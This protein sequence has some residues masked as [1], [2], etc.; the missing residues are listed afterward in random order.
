MLHHVDVANEGGDILSLPLGQP[1]SG[2]ILTGID[3]LDPG[4]AT[5]IS[6][7]YA[8]QDGSEFHFARRES[9]NILMGFA[10]DSRF[11]GGTTRL[12]REQLYKYFMPKAKIFL[13]MS[14][15]NDLEVQIDGVVESLQSPMF[16]EKPVAVASIIC[17]DPDFYEPN[18]LTVIGQSN[19]NLTEYEIDYTGTAA[20][21]LAVR[22]TV[23][24]AGTSSGFSI[25][26]RKPDTSVDILDFSTNLQALDQVF[27]NTVPGQKSATQIRSDVETSIMGNIDP[28]S[29][30]PKL[31]PGLNYIAITG[32][33][34]A[35]DFEISYFRRFGGL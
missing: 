16:T 23:P 25:Y 29:N 1:T 15:E 10:L 28:S 31:V 26:H 13:S 21:G 2:I 11:G 17:H 9:R 32:T 22:V 18:A 12:L 3:G 7:N 14:L 6:S 35:M 34:T 24:T 8:Q 20:T 30:W 4:K 27:V 33:G 5:L 19:V